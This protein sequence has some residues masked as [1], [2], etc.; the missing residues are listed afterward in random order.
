MELLDELVER[1]CYRGICI[2]AVVFVAVGLRLESIND[3]SLPS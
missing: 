1:F 2:I 3:A